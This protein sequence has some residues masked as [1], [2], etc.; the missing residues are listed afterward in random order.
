[1]RYKIAFLFALCALL[2]IVPLGCRQQSIA[3]EPAVRLNIALET[4]ED[5]YAICHAFGCS[6]EVV[7][8]GG[9]CNANGSKMTGTT[10]LDVDER[11][12]ALLPDPARTEVTLSITTEPGDSAP[13]TVVGSL[14]LPFDTV[15]EFD[16][17]IT[18][19]AADGYILTVQEY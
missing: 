7:Y 14:T 18:G 6:G 5:V 2:C 4:T 8:S 15:K 13:E 11:E 1:M 10:I 17:I 9:V 3:E 19:S 12:Y 16:L